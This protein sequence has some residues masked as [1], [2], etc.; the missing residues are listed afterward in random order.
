VVVVRLDLDGATVRRRGAERL[1]DHV[2]GPLLHLHAELAQ[3]ARRRGDAVALLHAQRGEALDARRGLQER[4]E[5]HERRRDVRHLRHVHG[6]VECRIEHAR[7]LDDGAVGIARDARAELLA[8]AEERVVALAG[9]RA[10]VGERDLRAVQHGERREVRRARRVALDVDL[11]GTVRL[12]RDDE[13]RVL[14]VL[15]V[16]AELRHLV[17]REIDVRL[18]REVPFDLDGEAVLEQRRD[19]QEAREVLARDGAG[20]ARRAAQAA[21]AGD[22]RRQVAV[23][24]RLERRAER[25]QRVDEVLVGTLLHRDVA[26]DERGGG[27]QRR[28]REQQARRDR[29]L[30]DVERDVAGREF[31][32]AAADADDPFLRIVDFEAEAAQAVLHAPVIV[33]LAGKADGARAVRERGDGAVAQRQRLAAGERRFELERTLRPGLEIEEWREI[34]FQRVSFQ[35]SN[36]KRTEPTNASTPPISPCFTQFRAGFASVE[37]SAVMAGHPGVSRGSGDPRRR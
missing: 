2:V 28:E 10:E 30:A 11:A 8:Q 25:A 7:A 15:D 3:L 6:R 31:A 18:A 32:A 24:R 21:R 37:G 35:R 26:V 27:T 13:A 12:R 22:A 34:D 19:G 16:H 4:R 29:A 5:H 23:A 9:A 17:E 33:A 36:E 14:V 20:H 1:D